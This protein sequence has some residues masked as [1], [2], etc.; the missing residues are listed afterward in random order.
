MAYSGPYKVKNREKYEGDPDTITY[1]SGW[2]MYAF[3]WCDDSKSI[4]KWSSEEV[5]VPY[6][7]DVDKRRHR[8]YTDLKITFTNGRTILV[9]IKP[10]KQT[11][12]PKFPGKRTKHYIVEAHTYIKNQNKW[13]AAKLYAENRGW[14]FE[15]WTE[16]DLYKMGIMKKPIKPLKKLKPLKP[17]RVKKPKKKV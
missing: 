11:I 14:Q 2:E 12:K 16:H 9:E 3:K 10:A 8:Y 1:R 7:Y 6:I 13:D 5:V 17:L 15:I 4:K